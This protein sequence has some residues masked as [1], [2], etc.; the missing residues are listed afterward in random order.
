VVIQPERRTSATEAMSASVMDGREK[1][2]KSFRM[3]FPK[4]FF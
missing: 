1:G 2:R 4:S 3:A